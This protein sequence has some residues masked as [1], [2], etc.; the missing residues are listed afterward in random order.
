MEGLF[1]F[2]EVRKIKTSNCE[3][4]AKKFSY[5]DHLED[6]EVHDLEYNYVVEV[7][8]GNGKKEYTIGKKRKT[9]ELGVYVTDVSEQSPELESEI[10]KLRMAS[11]TGNFLKRFVNFAGPYGE[12]VARSRQYLQENIHSLREK[13]GIEKLA[14][15]EE[16]NELNDLLKNA[17][18]NEK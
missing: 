15:A 14:S 3:I 18:G 10:R 1:P 4:N 7:D 9:S 16:V 6:R 12:K 13:A 5:S 2:E 8:D 11:V 17:L